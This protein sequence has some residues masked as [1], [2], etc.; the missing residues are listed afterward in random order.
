MFCPQCGQQQPSEAVRFCKRCG[1]SLEGLGRFVRHPGR[2]GS[3]DEDEARGL[4]PRQRGVRL[5]LLVTVAGL[6]FGGVA[7]LLMAMKE[8]LFVLLPL[9]ALVFTVGVVRLL[10]GLLL[11]GDAP[12]RREEASAAAGD[13]RRPSLGGIRAGELPPARAVPI[14]PPAAARPDTTD[15]AAPRVSITERTTELLE[16]EK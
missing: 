7:T 14:T 1:L 12:R 16:E 5:G 9:A 15:M 3:G 4:S 8:D 11:E 13:A 6:L 2:P 10:Y